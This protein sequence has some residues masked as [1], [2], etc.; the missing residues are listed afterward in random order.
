MCQFVVFFFLTF[1][2]LSTAN[3]AGCEINPLSANAPLLVENGKSTIIYPRNGETT[4]KFQTGD[5]VDFACPQGKVIA[6][7][8]Q[9]EA[10]VTAT[11]ISNQRFS[12]LEERYL[13]RQV[14]CNHDPVVT[15]RFVNGNCGGIGRL[16]EIGFVLDSKRFLQTMSICFDTRSQTTLYSHFELT[17]SIGI[18]IP[19]SPRP[20]FQEDN[21]F[22]NLNGR[23]LNTFYVR[24][25]QRRTINGLLDLEN[26]SKTYIQDGTLFFLSR[27]HLTA[28]ADFIYPAQRNATFRYINAAPQWQ[29]FN[30]H[31]WEQAERH[32]R[33]YASR[34]NVTLQVWTGTYGV[35]TLPHSTT[36]RETELFLYVNSNVRAIPVPA[37]FWKIVYNPSSRRGIVL[38]G[39]QSIGLNGTD[40]ISL[41]GIHMLA[42]LL[43]SG[44]LLHMHLALRSLD[45]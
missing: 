39:T 24:N 21:G 36:G 8:N 5:E 16:A 28:N 13:W 18:R 9:R 33:N 44:K 34:N 31:N 37:I 40:P 41:M 22:Y 23:P 4:V 1:R 27:G 7:G 32:T 35:T 17:P 30:G 2:F 15:S 25:V 3:A 14:S 26:S 6:D 43:T 20:Q 42:Q 19:D 29:S 12:I 38:I 10:I 45:C 11:C